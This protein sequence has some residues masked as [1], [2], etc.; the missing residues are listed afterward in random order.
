MT[1]RSVYITPDKKVTVLDRRCVEVALP[2]PD[3]MNHEEFNQILGYLRQHGEAYPHADLISGKVE[4][5]AKD[6]AFLW[7]PSTEEVLEETYKDA[8][9]PILDAVHA[10]F[11]DAKERGAEDYGYILV[12]FF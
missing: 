8:P 1:S 12:G 6:E 9:Q 7:I 10:A 5:A 11:I 3:T 4:L 2:D